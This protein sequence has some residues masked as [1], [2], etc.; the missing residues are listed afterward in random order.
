MQL[1]LDLLRTFV[2]IVETGGFTRA[3]ERLNKT[4]S[5]VSAQIKKLEEQLGQTRIARD[6]RNLALTAHGELLLERGRERARERGREERFERG[7][8][9]RRG[10]RGDRGGRRHRDEREERPA[11]RWT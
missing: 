9:D 3:A 5:T 6:T 2:A 7:R 1:E 10:E 4:Q 8:R 11:R